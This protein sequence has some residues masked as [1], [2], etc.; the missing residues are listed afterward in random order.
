[1]R[2]SPPGKTL[3]TLR[4]IPT[5]YFRA[6]LTLLVASAFLV[7]FVPAASAAPLSM[8]GSMEGD[9]KV[10]AGDTLSAGYDLVM[11]GQH[12]G[13][14]VE[15]ANAR[16]VFQATCVTG[17][18]GGTITIPL[19]AGPYS[20]PA[21]DNDWYPSGDQHSPLVYQGSTAV[22]DLCGGGKVRIQ[23]GGTFTADVRSTNTA[24]T[25]HVRWHYSANGS[26]GSWSATA[27]V[28]APTA[29]TFTSL[30]ATR[31]SH[32]VVLGWHTAQENGL[33]GFNVYREQGSKVVR[34]NAGLIAASGGTLGQSYRFVDHRAPAGATHYRV[35]AI[36]AD[37]SRVWLPP[38]SVARS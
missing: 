26:S 29:A 23:D 4:R 10:D 28:N 24:D 30:R 36:R 16:V 18:G 15:L 31:S 27:T 33:L 34:L 14:T 32:G 37:G 38:L 17:S 35:Q 13:A 3:L 19:S 5:L 6:T 8:D 12:D 9:L 22:P 7:G 11:P 20:V 21:G 2:V 1:M 25:I